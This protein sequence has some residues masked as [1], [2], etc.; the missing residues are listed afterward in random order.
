V[1]TIAIATQRESIATRLQSALVDVQAGQFVHV[2]DSS[3]LLAVVLEGNLSMVL[4]DMQSFG[5]TA[6]PVIHL[7][8]QEFRTPVVALAEL[9]NS[10]PNDALEAGAVDVL[11]F[12]APT[13]EI[14]GRVK[15][16]LH[17]AE[18][19]GHT[20]LVRTGELE[21]NLASEEL[22]VS[23]QPVH[24]TRT[25][26]DIFRILAAN[27]GTTVSDAELLKTVWGPEYIDAVEYLRVYIGYIRNKIDSNPGEYALADSHIARERGK[28]YR[29]QAFTGSSPHR[30]TTRTT[31][32]LKGRVIERRVADRRVAE[33]LIAV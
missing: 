33:R 8:S 3:E 6:L 9:P 18:R 28:G 32:S 22:T 29:L 13:S 1:T 23:G 5:S 10:N 21:Y 27:I 31:T 25:E 24:L 14:S 15:A 2:R 26:G 12:F 7:L 19:A 20:N 4:M 16:A 30:I 17:R 11:N